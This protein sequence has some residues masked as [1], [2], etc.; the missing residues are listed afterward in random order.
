MTGGRR[1][2]TGKRY[3]LIGASEG[4]GLALARLLSAAGAELVLSARSEAT[5]IDRSY[6]LARTLPAVID[7]PPD[8]RIKPGVREFL[9][10]VLSREG[11]EAINRDGR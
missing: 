2:F 11:Q 3:W 7:H 4:L 10:Y 9:R 5:L 1:D 6:P 8:G